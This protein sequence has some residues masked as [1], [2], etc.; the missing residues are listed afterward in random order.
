MAYIV[1]KPI[2]VFSLSL[3]QAEQKFWVKKFLVR[4][5]KAKKKLLPGYLKSRIHLPRSE[6]LQQ[7]PKDF[8]GRKEDGSVQE[9]TKDLGPQVCKHPTFLN[10]Y[11]KKAE[12]NKYEVII[13]AVKP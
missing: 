2:L 3:S 1:C 12:G 9:G 11:D 8:E 5:I 7:T 10:R 4:K 13:D 6:A